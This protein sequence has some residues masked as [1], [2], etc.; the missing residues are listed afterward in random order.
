MGR[1]LFSQQYTTTTVPAVRVEPEHVSQPYS[2]WD[3]LNPFDPDS[4]EFFANAELETPVDILPSD[5]DREP[6]S[7]VL[8]ADSSASDSSSSGSASP[9]QEMTEDEAFA[10]EDSELR[11]S[12]R[13][14]GRSDQESAYTYRGNADRAP[15]IRPAVLPPATP[16][17]RPM[18]Y[19]FIDAP[20]Q[21]VR[22][23]SPDATALYMPAAS[24]SAPPSTPP[25]STPTLAARLLEPSPPPS[26]TPRL[27]SWNGHRAGQAAPPGSPSPAPAVPQ[28]HPGFMPAPP[29]LWATRY[30]TYT[31]TSSGSPS[32]GSPL[33]NLGAR[34]SVAHITPSITSGRI[35]V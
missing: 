8:D 16:V 7:P 25:P 10:V 20:V 27:Y 9:T 1:P 4:D 2:R 21:A 13:R 6:Y 5:G 22:S 18:P 34:M 11:I 32:A 12:R 35:R 29:Q 17:A 23:P 30:P 24:A 28:L 26:V 15:R 3:Y 33:P 31:Y 19:Y 14:A